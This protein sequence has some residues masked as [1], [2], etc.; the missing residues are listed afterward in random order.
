MTTTH[1]LETFRLWRTDFAAGRA[2]VC[3]TLTAE[4]AA[5]ALQGR[6]PCADGSVWSLVES[7]ECREQPDH[8]DY[9][10]QQVAQ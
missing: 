5:A 9:T 4:D 3:T 2:T 8:N 10:F 7:V 1:D 6:W